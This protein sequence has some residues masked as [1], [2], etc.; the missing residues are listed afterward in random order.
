MQNAPTLYRP[1][2]GIALFNPR[3][4]VFLGRRKNA[5]GPYIWQLPQGGI[6]AGETAKDAAIR[7][8]EEETGIA[9]QLITPLGEIEDWLHYDFPANLKNSRMARQW[10]G[11]KQRWFAFRFIGQDA[12]IDLTV[13]NEIEFSDWRWDS[14]TQAVKLIVPFKRSVYERVGAEF[15]IFEK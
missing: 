14:L 7:E 3:G 10:R 2:A 9:P 13:H 11:Q 6:D 8:L 4:Q 5:S 15:S 1:A 12:Q